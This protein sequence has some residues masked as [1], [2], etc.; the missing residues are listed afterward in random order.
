MCQVFYKV[1]HR[2]FFNG[3]LIIV[4]LLIKRRKLGIKH[5]DALSYVQ[6]DAT[7]PNIVGPTMLGVIASVC[8]YNV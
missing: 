4:H 8:T 5:F 2:W 1:N 7:I 6:T 3:F